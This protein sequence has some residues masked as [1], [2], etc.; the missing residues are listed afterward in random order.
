MIIK[1]NHARDGIGYTADINGRNIFLIVL[2]E[3]IARPSITALIKAAA[4]AGKAFI[5]LTRIRE[6]IVLSTISRKNVRKVLIGDGSNQFGTKLKNEI[7][8]QPIIIRMKGMEPI[9]IF[10]KCLFIT[11]KNFVCFL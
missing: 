8:D 3:P 2:D 9:M 4:R 7:A 1:G 5:A 10:R 6:G 11:I